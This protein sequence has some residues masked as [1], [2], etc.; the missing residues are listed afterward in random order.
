MIDVYGR[1][2]KQDLIFKC[3]NI[4]RYSPTL[5]AQEIITLQNLYL[6]EN[7]IN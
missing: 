3:N 6:L 1:I 2:S 4:I 5:E 7:Q